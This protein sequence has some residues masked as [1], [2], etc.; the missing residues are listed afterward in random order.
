MPA[1][2]VDAYEEV[3]PRNRKAWRQWLAKNHAKSP[4]IWL[5]LEKKGGPNAGRLLRAEAVEEALCYGWIDSVPRK[6]DERVYLLLM[7]PRKDGSEWSAVNKKL[8][9]KLI[10]AKLM[11]AAGLAKIEAAKQ[12]GSWAKLEASDRLEVPP[13]LQKAFA[14]NKT[15]RKNFDAFPPGVRKNILAWILGAK[16]EETRAKR[17]AETVAKAAENVRVNQW[18]G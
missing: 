3:S 15:A 14:K 1:S 11:T 12:D 2:K 13:D 17:V 18:R 7:T 16:R 5:V 8:V 10:E 6:R 4:G 9:S